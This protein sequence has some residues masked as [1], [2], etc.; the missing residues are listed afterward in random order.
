MKFEI[1][2]QEN[3]RFCSC[4][5]GNVY[6]ARGG[7]SAHRGYMHLIIGVHDGMAAFVVINKD[8]EIVGA[9]SYGVHVFE[10]RVP[11]AYAEGLD[12]LSFSIKSL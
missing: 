8:G 11:I 1:E 4:V 10:D 12:G 3:D 7:R 2:I 6:P 9:S 5:V